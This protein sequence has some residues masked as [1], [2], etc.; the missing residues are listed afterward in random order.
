MAIAV[1]TRCLHQDMPLTFAFSALQSALVF[2]KA[3]LWDS[4]TAEVPLQA[5][6]RATS[7]VSDCGVD[8]LNCKDIA[9]PYPHH[10]SHRQKNMSLNIPVLFLFPFPLT[11]TRRQESFDPVPSYYHLQ[12]R[13]FA[14]GIQSRKAKSR[15]WGSPCTYSMG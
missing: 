8:R 9:L 6:S 12:L 11:R 3:L 13:H 10:C 15:L 14:A 5:F 4:F 1:I 2:F 7:I